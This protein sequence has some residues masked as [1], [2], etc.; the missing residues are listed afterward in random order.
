[1]KKH[2]CIIFLAA[3]MLLCACQP[4]PETEVVVNK[5]DGR[6]DEL[7]VESG[8]QPVYQTEPTAAND[9]RTN[10]PIPGDTADRK[11][12][13]P[14]M[15]PGKT[16][17][18]TIA[19][20]DRIKDCFSGKAIGDTLTVDLDADV[21]VPNI[22]RVP[23][24]T[25]RIEVP[26]G[27]KRDAMFRSL[28]GEKPY[29]QPADEEKLQIGNMIRYLNN[30]VH[31]LEEKPYGDS[32]PYEA[33]IQSCL[34]DIQTL[35]L[36]LASFPDHTEFTE[37]IF[38]SSKRSAELMNKNHVLVRQLQ[39]AQGNA[40]I[41]YYDLEQYIVINSNT[42]MRA[43]RNE[44]EQAALIAAE[45][46]FNGTGLTDTKATGIICADE[47][48]RMYWNTER[49]VEDGLYRVSLV[50]EYAGIPCYSYS[51]YYGSDSARTAAKA[52]PEYV[53]NP[54]QE[55]IYAIVQGE[56]VTQFVWQYPCEIVTM[57]NAN[58]SLLSF[59]EVMN[60]FQKQ[61]FMNVYLDKGFPETM[62]IT[63]IRFSYL[64]MKKLNSEDFYLLPVW[65]FL[66]YCTDGEADDPLSRSWYDNQSFLT[67]NAIDGSIID[68][69]VG[70]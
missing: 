2:I 37:A 27:E 24:F 69:N 25:V 46:F 14:T 48:R 19:A 43:P 22:S 15:Q 49:G 28:L 67:I 4:T 38:D 33:M 47:D 54:P 34:A 58:V 6:L 10:T 56:T 63:D 41:L 35:S 1:M 5:A 8:P 68:R 57:D 62:H 42:G 30:Y 39:D 70:Y 9:V 66:G 40:A 7:I 31:T 61:I 18:N 45:S 32:V 44:R 21:D 20:P 17:R 29:Y 51:T 12:P 60:I 13:F 50:P 59:D 65:D 26:T 11:S 23:V 52:D 3:L 53:W 36:Q 16:L 64:R 55:T